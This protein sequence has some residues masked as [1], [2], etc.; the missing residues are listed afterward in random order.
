MWMG[1][2]FNCAKA[3]HLHFLQ[4]VNSHAAHL[5][6]RMSQ[7]LKLG[8]FWNPAMPAENYLA[9]AAAGGHL[10]VLQWAVGTLKPRGPHLLQIALAA[11]EHGHLS[12]LKWAHSRGLFETAKLCSRAANL[13]CLQWAHENG[14]PLEGRSLV[15]FTGTLQMLQWLLQQGCIWSGQVYIEA[16][17]AG[18]LDIIKWAYQQGLPFP[19]QQSWWTEPQL[20]GARGEFLNTAIQCGHVPILE[21]AFH[22]GWAPMMGERHKKQ[23]RFI[24]MRWLRANN[25]PWVMCATS[26]AAGLIRYP[27]NPK[28]VEPLKWLIENGC[29]LSSKMVDSLVSRGFVGLAR[30]VQRRGAV[31]SGP[32]LAELELYSQ[33]QQ[34]LCRCFA[35]ACKVCKTSPQLDQRCC[36]MAAVPWEL[37]QR[38]SQLAFASSK[39]TTN[40][41][42]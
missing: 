42:A 38:I 22:N 31:C 20:G 16:A 14:Y 4:W 19:A 28:N 39:K 33:R 40:S 2:L 6:A 7:Q 37:Q 8:L 3:G 5:D 10:H 27:R 12:I 11:A 13:E 34:E 9:G 29:P 17:A 36:A 30:W 1:D 18:K 41:V 24:V 15:Q 35:L 25:C 32:A 23:G 21:W 26:H